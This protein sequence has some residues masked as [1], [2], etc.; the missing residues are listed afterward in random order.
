MPHYTHS[1]GQFLTAFAE[2][3][4]WPAHTAIGLLLFLPSAL[5]IVRVVSDRAEPSDLRWVNVA[6]LIWVLAQ[7]VAL[8][9]GRAQWALQSRYTG[10]LLIGSMVNLVSAFWLFQSYAV[11]SKPSGGRVIALA[12]WLGV[13]ALS[14]THPQRHLRNS[15]DERRDIA[16]AA[17]RNLRSYLATGDASFL[18]GPPALQ[19]R[20]NPLARTARYTGNPGRPPA[21][22]NGRSAA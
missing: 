21:G 6:V 9:V 20:F 5:F 13:F 17:A 12:A 10:V 11:A 4:F 19:I 18:A 3:V 1:V 15:I 16:V 22:P 7:V 14:L 8:A 2:L